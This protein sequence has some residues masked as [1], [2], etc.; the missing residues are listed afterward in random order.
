VVTLLLFGY[1]I[2]PDVRGV[3]REVA[4]VFQQFAQVSVDSGYDALILIIALPFVSLAAAS[5]SRVIYAIRVRNLLRALGIRENRFVSWNVVVKFA[6]W[7]LAFGFVI[8]CLL[9]YL[10]TPPLP[11]VRIGGEADYKGSLLAHAEGYWYVFNREGEL[12][13]IPDEDA[14]TVR[15]QSQDE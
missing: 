13:A 9:A 10:K 4:S 6:G 3:V 1:V 15:I 7:T 14:K 2:W 5:A 11:I 12:I 8:G